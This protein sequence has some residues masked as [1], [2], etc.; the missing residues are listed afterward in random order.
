MH[1]LRKA[2]KKLHRETPKDRSGMVGAVVGRVEAQENEW[3]Q[4]S[5]QLFKQFDD[6]IIQ[7]DKKIGLVESIYSDHLRLS[8]Q[9]ANVAEQVQ[10][11]ARW[12]KPSWVAAILEVRTGIVILAA[13]MAIAAAVFAWKAQKQ[14]HR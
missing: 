4:R 2:L 3:N 10:K 12:I 9:I 14:G 5:E 7:L 13:L 6:R 1:A 8:K 11:E